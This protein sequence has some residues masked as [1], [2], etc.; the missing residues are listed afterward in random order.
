MTERTGRY[1]FAGPVDPYTY[2]TPSVPFLHSLVHWLRVS[3]RAAGLV[4]SL[5]SRSPF[6]LGDSGH[7]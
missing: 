2:I 1:V 6:P 3:P 5:T 7:R 4:L